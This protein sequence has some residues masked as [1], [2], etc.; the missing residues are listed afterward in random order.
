MSVLGGFAIL[1]LLVILAIIVVLLGIFG[2]IW[3][4]ALQNTIPNSE[5][6]NKTNTVGEIQDKADL[7]QFIMDWFSKIFKDMPVP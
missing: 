5:L 2:G 4:N 7:W 6:K 3:Y 1:A